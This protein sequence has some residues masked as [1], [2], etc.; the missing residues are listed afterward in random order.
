[1]PAAVAAGAHDLL[2]YLGMCPGR[3]DILIFDSP[4]EAGNAAHTLRRR[5]DPVLIEVTA[6]YEKVFIKLRG[7][8]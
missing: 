2:D 6:A 1:M 3:R 8:G 7:A 5:S 4:E